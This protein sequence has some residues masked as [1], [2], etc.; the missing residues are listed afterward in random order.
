[1]IVKVPPDARVYF[2]D[3]LMDRTGALR[4]FYTPELPSG[5]SY[6]YQVRA[7]VWRQGQRVTQSEK[8]SVR[9]G[10][11]TRVDLSRLGASD[12]SKD[13]IADVPRLEGLHDAGG[14]GDTGWP[15]QIVSAENTVCL[16]QPQVEKWQD[17]RLTARAAVT[18]GARESPRPAYG[19]LWLTARTQVDREARQVTLDDFQIL[20]VSFPAAADKGAAYLAL[21]RATVPAGARVIAL[22]R[23]EASLAT[24]EDAVKVPTL[25][26]KNDVPRILFTT[27]PAVLILIDGKPVLRRIAGSKLRR[28]INTRAI[29]LQDEAT[30]KYYVHVLDGWQEAR[31]L[32][33]PWEPADAPPAELATVLR[34]LAEDPRVDLLDDPAPDL[35]ESLE[36][37]RTLAVYASTTPAELI[38]TR[39]EPSFTA[40]GG[41]KLQ[42]A[43][44]TD[45]DLILDPSTGY[46]YLLLSGRWL[47][48]RSLQDGWQFV[49]GD[50]LPDDFTRI[51]ETHLLGDVLASVAGTSQAREALIANQ[52]PQTTIIKR[53]LAKLSPIFDGEPRL[54]PLGSTKL[55][56]A[57]N[58][59]TPVIEAS[60]SAYYA[61]ENG[62]WFTAA[63]AT[64][65]WTVATSVPPVIY[66]IP[67]SAPL[68]YA[69]FVRVYDVT[70]DAV[71]VGYTPGYF[72]TCV[73]PWGTVVYG[74]GWA[75]QPWVGQAW[76]GRAWTYGYAARFR[77]SSTAGWGFGFGAA[78]GRPWWRPLSWP[79]DWGDRYAHVHASSIQVNNVN[80]YNRWPRSALLHDDTRAQPQTSTSRMVAGRGLNN[81]YAGRDGIIYRPTAAGWEAYTATGTWKTVAGSSAMV[82]HLSTELAARRGAEMHV[83]VFQA[84]GGFA[85][86][87]GFRAGAQAGF[88]GCALRR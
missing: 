51:P 6:K 7:E 35:K 44:N 40:I 53:S 38:E 10:E 26:L 67:P 75:Y 9:V 54:E 64:G 85:G 84:S 8:I 12:S 30:G 80:V 36:E 5:V 4:T 57:V 81:L 2:N 52:I 48:S 61:V 18:V 78:M 39:G 74:T 73:A 27:R 65:P 29:M 19:V 71:N 58:S 20:K 72:G 77:C 62:V 55:R 11:I 69:T 83:L 63:A 43:R 33:G 50:R 3:T 16:Y 47:K 32:E 82:S 34:Q 41:T 87:A 59:P 49:A 14:P 28:V 42:A 46:H 56:Y 15:R 66:T 68:Y 13:P 23:I 31:N 21:L 24:A 37:G 45:A 76:Y 25:P 1:V 79:S 60:P 22:D 88:R 70:P 17:N 86:Y